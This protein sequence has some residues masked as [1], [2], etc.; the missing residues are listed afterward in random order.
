MQTKATSQKR[1]L[2]NQNK[3]RAIVAGQEQN[4]SCDVS[5]ISSNEGTSIDTGSALGGSSQKNQKFHLKK[6]TRVGKKDLS[7][8]RDMESDDEDNSDSSSSSSS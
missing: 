1:S 2:S 3:S 4:N 5:N 6:N 8:I 7:E